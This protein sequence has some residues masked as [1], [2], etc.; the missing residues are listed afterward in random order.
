[1]VFKFLFM[2]LILFL[3]I[4]RKDIILLRIIRCKIL[5]N[6]TWIIIVLLKLFAVVH[7]LRLL[8]IIILRLI[9]GLFGGKSGTNWNIR[10]LVFRIILEFGLR[11]KRLIIE[12]GVVFV[13]SLRLLLIC[14]IELLLMS[15]IWQREGSSRVASVLRLYDWWLGLNWGDDLG[16]GW[17]EGLSKVANISI[18]EK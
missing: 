16:S 2:I 13:I 5:W 7:S 8:L 12:S 6:I 4:L 11:L 10:L 9:L 3:L 15:L 1:M 18:C 17:L 14:L